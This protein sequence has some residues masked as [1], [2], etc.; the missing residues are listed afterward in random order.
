MSQS[1]KNHPKD[2]LAT[3]LATTLRYEAQIEL[4]N[5]LRVVLKPP[6]HMTPELAALVARVSGTAPA[7]SVEPM[8]P[9]RIVCTDRERPPQPPS[10]S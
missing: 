5:V 1:L 9:G 6:D 2:N 3:W 10:T 7:V 8:E 4:G